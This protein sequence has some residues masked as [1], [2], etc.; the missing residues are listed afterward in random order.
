[1][2]DYPENY[3]KI[4]DNDSCISVS[5]S[6]KWKDSIKRID[7]QHLIMPNII[8]HLVPHAKTFKTT[9]TKNLTRFELC[10]TCSQ[11]F[12]DSYEKDNERYSWVQPQ[13]LVMQKE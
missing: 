12:K 7:C 2:N 9:E 6:M 4:T 1:M 10:F 8:S 3:C 13:Q 11:L 5:F